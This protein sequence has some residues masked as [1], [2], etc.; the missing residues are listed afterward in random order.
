MKRNDCKLM[1]LYYTF[2]GLVWLLYSWNGNEHV[3]VSFRVNSGLI[4]AESIKEKVTN[5]Y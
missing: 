1:M 4:V 5:P 3:Q 2:Y